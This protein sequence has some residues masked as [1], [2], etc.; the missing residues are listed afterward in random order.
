MDIKNAINRYSGSEDIE[1]HFV[2]LISSW[3]RRALVA[4]GFGTGVPEC[5][6][7]DASERN[8]S[9]L[10]YRGMTMPDNNDNRN[11]RASRRDGV[12]LFSTLEDDE[13]EDEFY[14]QRTQMWMKKLWLLVLMIFRLHRL[15]IPSL[16][17][18]KTTTFCCR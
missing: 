6:L 3:S 18:S 14:S 13:C 4:A 7:V 15:Q 8:I 16:P 12:T 11:L 2:G 10:P 9:N 5:H 1:Y 17:V